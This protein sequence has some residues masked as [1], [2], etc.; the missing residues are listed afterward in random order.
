MNTEEAVQK[1]SDVI[2]RKHLALATEQSYCAWLKRYCNFIKDFC[3]PTFP[4]SKNSN[5]F[6]RIYLPRICPPAPGIKPSMP[7]FSFTRKRS[8]RN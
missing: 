7:L 6:S 5:G 8:V 4:A 1:L 3:L 2:R